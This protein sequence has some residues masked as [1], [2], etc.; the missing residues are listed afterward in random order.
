[1]AKFFFSTLFIALSFCTI[2]AQDKA[3]KALEIFTQ[4]YPQEKIHFIFSKS[5]YIAGEN[6][7]FKAF[8]FDGYIPSTISTSLF[9]ELYDQ[10]KKQIDKK[11]IPLIN[12]EGSG[13]FQLSENLKEDIYYIRAYTTWMANFNE[14]FQTLKPVAVYNPSSPE[15]LSKEDH[16]TWTA[17][18]FPESGTFIDGISTKFS[19]RLQS[20]GPPP[21]DWSGYVTDT[22][23]PE[24]KITSFK[25]LD[26]NTGTFSLTPKVNTK[27]RLIVADSKGNQQTVD[28]P[29]VQNSGINLQ[30]VTDKSTIKITLKGKNIEPNTLYKIIGS[31]DNQLVFKARSTQIIEK[32]Y[33]IPTD[34]LINGII[35]FTV[36]DEEENV[37]AQRLCFV[38]PSSLKIEKPA[39][40][41]L[42]LKESP[43]A[44]NSFEIMQKLEN[45]PYT[46][47]VLDGKS[48]NQEDENSLLSTIWLTGDITSPIYKPS[49]YF[50][51]EN[52]SE[53]LDALL[54]S[55]KW[56]RFDWR[57]IISGTYPIISYKPQP[58]ITYK[59][60][61]TISEKPAAH[62]ELNLLFDMPDQG[63]KF[64]QIKTDENGFF[65]LKGLFFEGAVKFS[66][67]LNDP[68]IP[69][70]Q[71]QVIFQPE[72]AFI[73][74]KKSLPPN[75]YTLI[76][77]SPDE[78]PDNYIERYIALKNMEKIINE[79]ETHIE[80]IKLK[81]EKKNKTKELNEKLSSPLFRGINER[82]FDL[83]NNN[84]SAIGSTNILQWLE[85]RVAGL[86]MKSNTGNFV[87]Q[88]RG[89]AINIYLDEMIIDPQ[90]IN[91]ISISD[92]AMVKVIKD[93]FFGGVGAGFGAI[94]IYTRR[95]GIS[96]TPSNTS[97]PT[98]LKQ[99]TLNGFDKVASFVSPSY[100]NEYLK[101]IPLDYRSILYWN[102]YLEINPKETANIQ[103][104]NND[105]AQN[106][107]IVIMG[108]DRNN[109]TPV[110]YNEIAK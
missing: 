79:N 20:S 27:Y 83:V 57:T 17:A 25:G 34:K 15:K 16:S 71:V 29:T 102:P 62:T 49:Q 26:Q 93:S 67:Q 98:K 81:G 90:N 85:G 21:S 76:K 108:F 5:S 68:K 24:V 35:Q 58:Y 110:Y 44:S 104:F 65:S 13:S 69:K 47:F 38:Q 11:F 48:E 56:K 96:G 40:H 8:V 88:L 61:I 94:A 9:V 7:W 99:V 105:D 6:L 2:Y 106:Y 50:T 10:N 77:R 70:E 103:F 66:Y 97:A 80:E 30:V 1:M 28:L 73:P 55:E 84:N 54:I 72:Y 19:V 59:G 51:G 18:A 33:S 22:E 101:N 43:R 4:K 60:K 36:F 63:T 92:I 12:G 107:R 46:V 39:I 32:T 64:Y 89:R 87:P 3:E 109:Y 14:D 82:V 86:T 31:M 45:T 37:I 78:K 74:Y 41:S 75:N 42:S 95:G 100:D 91:S 52:K 23:K 53:A